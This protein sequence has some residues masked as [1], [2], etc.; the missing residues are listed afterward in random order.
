MSVSYFFARAVVSLLVVELLFCGCAA[1]QAGTAPAEQ[2]KWTA[3][4]ASIDERMLSLLD[5]GEFEEALAFADSALSYGFRDPRLLGQKAAA[6]GAL[7]KGAEAI[8]LYEEAILADYAGCDNH[9]DFGV[10]LMRTGRTGRAVTELREAKRFCQ[11]ENGILVYRN[12]AVAYIKMERYDQALREV[13]EGLA[14]G[15]GDPYLLGLKGMLLVDSNPALAE[16]LLAVPADSGAIEPEFLYQYGL[17]LLSSERPGQAAEVLAAASGL[18]PYDLEIRVV[19]AAALRRAGRLEELEDLYRTLASEGKD[20]VGLE[21]GKL[22][23]ERERYDEALQLLMTL[24]PTADVLD[25]TA[26]CLF[27]LGRSD[28]ALETERKAIE[29]R[30]DWP[31]TMINLAVILAARGELEEASDLLERALVIEPDNAAAL[32]NLERLKKA[33]EE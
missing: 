1:K 15:K 4:R 30:P 27:H 17:L 23:M 26:M 25:R 21:L 11:G 16:S 33:L 12:L 22:L 32:I 29:I 9:L 7:G 19:L 14:I 20:V 13:T 31:V 28:E 3:R 2:G 8:A 5:K 18:K 24:I 6:A 10:F